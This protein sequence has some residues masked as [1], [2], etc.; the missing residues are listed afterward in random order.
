[1]KRLLRSLAWHARWKLKKTVEPVIGR[2]AVLLL[3][4]LRRANRPRVANWAGASMRRIGPWLPEHRIGRANLAAAFP[5]MG[6]R[7]IENVLRGTW[8]N[9]GRVAAEFAY[10]DRLKVLHPGD[11]GP[12]D[13]SYDEVALRRFDE[14]RSA[15]RPTAFFAAHLANW[16]LPALAAARFGVDA[17]LLYRAPSIRPIAEAVLEIRKNCMGTLVRS[18]FDA[19]LRLA[20][21]LERGAHVGMLVDQHESRGVDVTF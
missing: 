16:E 4:A 12:A 5:E 21:A 15:S 3:R 20:H 14:I 19:P 11:P 1:M 13:A 18:G 10:L 8:E 6:A 2:L 17:S 9:L 7:D